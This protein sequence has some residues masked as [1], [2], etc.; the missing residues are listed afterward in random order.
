MVHRL[1]A[2]TSTV[3]TGPRT[4]W[5][6]LQRQPHQR[7][8]RRQWLHL[9]E[10][11][12]VS[13]MS[14]ATKQRGRQ[15]PRHSQTTCSGMVRKCAFVGVLFSLCTTAH[16]WKLKQPW[17]TR[18]WCNEVDNARWPFAYAKHVGDTE[19][20]KGLS[21]SNDQFLGHECVRFGSKTI[22]NICEDFK[23]G[24]DLVVERQ[25][26]EDFE[27]PSFIDAQDGGDITTCNDQLQGMN[28]SFLPRNVPTVN[29]APFA[30]GSTVQHRND[31]GSASR[32]CMIL[33]GG[34]CILPGNT[35]NHV[36]AIHAS[37]GGDDLTDEDYNDCVTRCW[38][39][40]VRYKPF[41]KERFSDEYSGYLDYA[42][43]EYYKDDE[44]QQGRTYT[45]AGSGF[46]GYVDGDIAMARF[47]RPHGIAVDYDGYVYVAD[48]HNHVIRKIDP[49]KGLVSTVAGDGIA[50][51]ADGRFDRARLTNPT[52]IALYYDHWTNYSEYPEY[53]V[54]KSNLADDPDRCAL[55]L[56]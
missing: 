10:K 19:E 21:A 32:V 55:S 31:F 47:N 1:C 14:A 34:K 28:Y 6:L 48:T 20:A 15:R 22:C 37:S 23:C 11:R 52:D 49:Y 29:A 12:I 16:G 54:G 24:N 50:G 46:E 56:S 3:V 45:V 25:T 7:L 18:Q 43:W 51:Y 44:Q 26:A 27:N 41:P 36:T 42:G 39:S 38:G 33:S 17:T 13:I 2:T 4:E 5:H 30:V 8:W 53:T 35:S 9:G 40:N